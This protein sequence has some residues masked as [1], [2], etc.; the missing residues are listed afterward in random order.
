MTGEGKW[1]KV[2]ALGTGE[3]TVSAMAVLASPLA[4]FLLF[5][6]LL[7]MCWILHRTP[8]RVLLVKPS[9]AWTHVTYL[10]LPLFAVAFDSRRCPANKQLGAV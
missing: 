3:G 6:S 5:S 2:E 4:G 8:A 10:F 7:Y 9:G 1:D